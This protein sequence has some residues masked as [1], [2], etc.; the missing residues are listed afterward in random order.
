MRSLNI[1][2]LVLITLKLC[3]QGWHENL[4]KNKKVEDLRLHNYQNAFNEYWDK[5]N[6]KDGY[7]INDDGEKQKAAGWKQ[8]KRWEYYWEN[9]VNQTTGDFPKTSAAMEFNNWKSRNPGSKNRNNSGS[10]QNLGPFASSGGYSGLGR[11]N[12]IAFHPTDIDTYWVGSPS[13]GIWATTDDGST[14]NVLSDNNDVLG[15]SDIAVSSN[16][17]IDSTLYIATGDKNGGSLN[18]LN[19]GQINDNNSVGVLKSIDGGSTWNSTGLTFAYNIQE[20]INRLLID[21]TDNDI[22]YAATSL[23]VFW[24]SDGGANWTSTVSSYNWP[25]IDLEFKPGDSSTLYGSTI[26]GDVYISTD[27]GINFV[28]T[29]DTDYNRTE[30][31]VSAENPNII[32]ALL[33]DSV[34]KRGLIYK[35]ENS[36]SSFNLIYDGPHNLLGYKCSGNDNNTQGEYD[37]CISS[38]PSNSNE[39]FV[40]G[41][42]TWKS[43][44]G[45]LSWSINTHWESPSC[46]SIQTVHEDKHFLAYQNDSTLFQCNDG[47]IYKYNNNNL[48]I[49]LSND[50]AISQIYRIGISQADPSLILSGLQDNGTKFRDLSNNWN[51]VL[52]GDGMECIIDTSIFPQYSSYI[53][54]DIYKRTDYTNI[55]SITKDSVTV[56][57]YNGINMSEE[58]AW[59][60][61]YSMN[62]A[63]S[64]TLYLGLKD[65]WKTVN[66][67]QHWVKRGNLNNSQTLRSLSVA[68]S[69]SNYLYVASL[70]QLW[71]TFDEGQNWIERTNG[72]PV[73]NNSITYITVKNTDPNTIWITFGGYDG[74][75]VFESIDAGANWVNISEGLPNLPIMSVVCNKQSTFGN[76]LYVGTDRG[77]Y[78]KIGSEEWKLFNSGLPNVVVS[79]LEI[80]YD[81]VNPLNSKLRAGTYG[82]GLW[83]SDLYSY[84]TYLSS[85]TIQANTAPV[86]RGNTDQ[87]ILRVEIV[88]DGNESLLD[89]TEFSFNAN[90]CTNANVD[91]TSA[92]LYYTATI[93]TFNASTEFGAISNPNNDFDIYGTQELETG[94]NYFWLT[95]DIYEN[96]TV[97][98]TI[99]AECI[100]IKFGGLTKYPTVSDPDGNR[101][102]ICDYCDSFGFDF[103]DETSTTNVSFNTINNNSLRNVSDLGEVYSDFTNVY[104]DVRIDGKYDLSVKVTS[105]DYVFTKVWIDWNKNCVF[106]AGEEYDLGEA[107]DVVDGL[108]SNSPLEI[109]VPSD[110]IFGTTVMRVSTETWNPY[111]LSCGELWTG[112]VEDYTINIEPGLSVWIG[113]NSNWSDTSNWE[114]GTVPN[115]TRDVVIPSNPSGGSSPVVDDSTDAKWRRLKLEEDAVMEV[116][117]GIVLKSVV[118]SV[119]TTAITNITSSSATGGGNISYDGDIVIISRGVCWSKSPNPTTANNFSVDSSGVGVFTSMLTGLQY[120]ST[121]YVRAYGSSNIGTTYGNEV[122]F[123]TPSTIP[124]LTTSSLSNITV[125]TALGGGN[126]ILDGGSPVTSRGVCYG[127]GQNPTIADYT[128]NDGGG[129]GSFTSTLT[130]LSANE[131]YFVKSYA[132]NNVGTAY[133][134]E[135]SFTTAAGSVTDPDGNV[136]YTII[137]GDQ[138]WMRENLNVGV[139]IDSYS[140]GANNGIIEKFCYDDDSTNCEIYGGLYNFTEMMQYSWD[141]GTQGICPTGWHIPTKDDVEAYIVSL[142]SEYA[143]QKSKESGTTHWYYPNYATN[144]SNFTA[145]PGGIGIYDNYWNH[146]NFNLKRNT[147][148][149]WT[150]TRDN[151]P[152]EHH[153][154]IFTME[155]DATTLGIS[156]SYYYY[157]DKIRSVRCIKD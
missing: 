156:K 41:I 89:V 6:I 118:P 115:S 35:S 25:F 51:D 117:G 1:I 99:D 57:W 23:G 73:T 68:P 10:W 137:V 86:E 114:D 17:I 152:G 66:K 50:L 145:L 150:S 52:T 116:D 16:Y 133:G 24:T 120:N 21:P 97:S 136:Y 63:N 69:D 121:Y 56:T 95:Y 126:I 135:L 7:Y 149:F 157:H 111:I 100:S 91:I 19:G 46:G 134:V 72:L 105:E 110:A 44:D 81:E 146:Y 104:T 58:G 88:T 94:V 38:N 22:L 13:G 70:Q 2:I 92:K 61:P 76:E 148:S 59:V 75:R 90:G 155:H 138:E 87:E 12:C 96:A 14:W 84:M 30:I 103:G 139:I 9:R 123:T 33:H 143:G 34:Q 42:N 83:E 62:P 32:Y 47:G 53:Y 39:V 18:G 124:Y 67:G 74:D 77:V 26:T 144:S 29:L 79:E 64:N 119:N 151:I 132:T 3:A 102:I 85:T 78:C 113:H 125:T 80:Y 130:G 37:L 48:W 40:G 11:L 27:A 54:G 45:G 4:P 60:T 28:K 142:G 153:P 106:Q 31:A 140:R 129:T 5:Y 43:S 112:E 107:F 131:T 49:D 82:R 15:V 93:D 141:E 127:T 108:T 101:S 55:I 109:E 147:G 71:V 8:F 128:T 122:S 154:Y 65:V 98:N 36:G 20:K